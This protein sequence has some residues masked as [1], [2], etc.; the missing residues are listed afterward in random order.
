MNAPSL[1]ERLIAQAEWLRKHLTATDLPALM[2]EA[3][4]ELAR[5][6]SQLAAVRLAKPGFG[7]QR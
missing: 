1:S 3:A 6:E 7:D 4:L 2:E 5:L